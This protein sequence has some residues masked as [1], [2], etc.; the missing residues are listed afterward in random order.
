[1]LAPRILAPFFS[2]V[3]RF[4]LCIVP[5]F[6]ENMVPMPAHALAP[7]Q[8]GEPQTRRDL[9][10]RNDIVRAFRLVDDEFGNLI[11]RQSASCPFALLT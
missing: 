5:R 8:R 6:V 11:Q 9:I 1:M 4:Y 7:K 2:R 3:L 10:L